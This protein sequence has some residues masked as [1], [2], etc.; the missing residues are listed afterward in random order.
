MLVLREQ[1]RFLFVPRARVGTVLRRS[2]TAFWRIAPGL[3]YNK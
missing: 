3:A 2:L 1:I